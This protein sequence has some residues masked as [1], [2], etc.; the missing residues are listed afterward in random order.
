VDWTDYLHE[1]CKAGWASPQATGATQP[2]VDRPKYLG[3]PAEKVTGTDNAAGRAFPAAPERSR[4]QIFFLHLSLCARLP[5]SLL[6]PRFARLR[7]SSP[8][9]S[10]PCLPSIT[11]A[12]RYFPVPP[13]PVIYTAWPPPPLSLVRRHR[14][15]LHRHTADALAPASHPRGHGGEEEGGRTDQ[16][17]VI[18]QG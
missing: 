4:R 18:W 12:P 7:L 16:S 10:L 6:F 11:L 17:S 5:R 9:F 2:T 14:H 1:D 8:P 3:P 13:A 15:Q